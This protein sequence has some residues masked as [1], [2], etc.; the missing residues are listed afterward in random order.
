MFAAMAKWRVLVTY[1][2]IF[3]FGSCHSQ[4]E[5]KSASP[6]AARGGIVCGAQRI[7][8]VRALLANKRVALLVNQTSLAGSAHLIDALSAYKIDIKKIFAPEHGFRG[9]AGAGDHVANGVDA[10][11]GIAIIS[12]YGDKKKPSKEDLKDVD[13][14]VFDIQDVGARF[15]T[16]IS[17]LHYLMEACAENDK[18]LLVLDRPNPNGWYVDGP[19]LKKEFQS[20]VGVDPI[21]VV[22]GLTVGEYAQMVNG[23]GWLKDSLHCKLKVV[24]CLNYEHAMRYSLPVRPSPNLP[25]DVAIYNY[26]SLCFF[27]GTDVS[28]GRG[29]DYP[30]QVFGSPLITEHKFSFRPESKPEAK[31]PPHANQDCFGFDLRRTDMTKGGINLSYL[32]KAYAAFGDTS[33]FFLPNLFFDKL[34]G[35]DELRKQIIAGKSESEIK[36]I[37]KTVLENYKRMRK[38]YLLYKDFE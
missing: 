7:D 26:P 37:W 33:K 13:V 29:T 20:F 27:E 24:T 19:L 38:K 4:N 23:E 1:C 10:K 36:T 9:E 30:F 31:N 34:A 17:S 12:M 2:C 11:T 6:G 35:T 18:E 3:W 16:F 22:H 14:V 5:M 15:Y 21:P 28:V 32:L 25:N 8:E